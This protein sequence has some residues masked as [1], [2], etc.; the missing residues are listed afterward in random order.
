M[1]TQVVIVGECMLELSRPGASAG[2]GAGWQL[3]FGG[4]TFNTAF[5]LNRLGVGVS[6][7]TALGTDH[8]SAELRQA[9]AAE[10]IDLSMVLC[11]PDRIPGLYAIRTDPAGGR[12]FSYW[13][14]QSAA[15]QL[16]RSPRIEEA[17]KVARTARLLYLSGIT[18]SI[19]GPD[20]RQ[21]LLELAHAVRTAGGIVAFDPNYRPAC[22]ESVAAAR[23][24][25][26]SFA[27]CASIALPTFDD[28]QRLWGDG[29]P[30]HT[31]QRWQGDGAP[32]IVVKQGAACCVISMADLRE[33]VPAI[34]VSQVVDAT[35]AGDSFNAGYLAARL[36]G[37][38]PV[39]AARAGHA[40][41]ASVIQHSGAIVRRAT[42]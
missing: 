25:M 12:T 37:D 33:T 8:F 22:W 30:E 28:E 15:R 41:A 14:T 40:L 13:R 10:G 19:F 4:D 3:G 18:L 20:D 7:L 2:L 21:R 38:P 32:E 34:S 5:Y 1:A 35:G 23:I 42:D 24:M 29:T 39:V 31:I 36:R 26:A 6:Y 27:S 11:D 9:W 16:F 17:L